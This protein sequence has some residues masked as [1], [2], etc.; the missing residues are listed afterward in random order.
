MKAPVFNLVEASI[1]I[2][3]CRWRSFEHIALQEYR[4]IDAFKML[5]KI[6]DVEQMVK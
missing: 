4:I 3:W 1:D 2:V 6:N 5:Q